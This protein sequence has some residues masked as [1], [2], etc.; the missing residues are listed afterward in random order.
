MA[1]HHTHPAQGQAART[2]TLVPFGLSYSE[3]LEILLACTPFRPAA[4][5]PW[6]FREI[7]IRGLATDAPR[8]AFKLGMLGEDQ[9]ESLYQFIEAAHALTEHPS[10]ELIPAVEVD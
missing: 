5:P 10:D 6:L 2:R 1:V 3:A 8:L 7:L 4:V 9:L